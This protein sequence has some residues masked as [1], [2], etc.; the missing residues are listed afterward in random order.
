[1]NIR[2]PLV[3]LFFKGDFLRSYLTEVFTLGILVLYHHV[4]PYDND[5]TIRKNIIFI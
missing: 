4:T 1:M 5:L 2:L 3:N